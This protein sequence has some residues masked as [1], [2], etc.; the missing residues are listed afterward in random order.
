MCMLLLLKHAGS[1][2]HEVHLLLHQYHP[3][4]L[5]GSHHEQQMHVAAPFSTTWL[6]AELRRLLREKD[7]VSGAVDDYVASGAKA[8]AQR[9]AD[10]SS[11]KSRKDHTE[12]READVESQHQSA[13]LT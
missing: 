12:L 7:E 9:K 2:A 10:K 4:I 13:S 11:G 1:T 8:Q 5:A 3:R 6:L